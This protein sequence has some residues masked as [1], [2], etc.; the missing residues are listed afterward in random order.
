MRFAACVGARVRMRRLAHPA[1]QLYTGCVTPVCARCCCKQQ[2]GK[3]TV[4][5]K[6]R[7]CSAGC[8]RTRVPDLPTYYSA[9][10][11]YRRTKARRSN[12]VGKAL[13]V[14]KARGVWKVHGVIAILQS[15]VRAG[16]RG[17]QC[18]SIHDSSV[19]GKKANVRRDCEIHHGFMLQSCL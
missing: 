6:A 8:V 19:R 17:C 5:C 12:E 16:A 2:G 18:V 1:H 10:S 9:L 7:C 4:G 11:M 13:Y 14:I 15:T 3:K